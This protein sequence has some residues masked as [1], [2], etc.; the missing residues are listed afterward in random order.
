MDKYNAP[1]NTRRFVKVVVSPG[2]VGRPFAG[3]P[4]IPND[5][6]KMLREGFAKAMKDPE[7]L[8]D[9]KRR[10]WDAEHQPGEQLEALAREVTNQPADVI[11][12]LKAVL[13]Q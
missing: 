5:R 9:A 3:P 8:A 6:V 1:E 11:E 10:E 2:N 4:A 13:S 12:K 7:L